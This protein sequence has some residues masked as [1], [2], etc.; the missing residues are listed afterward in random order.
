MTAHFCCISLSDM[1]SSIFIYGGG[2][3]GDAHA[4]AVPFLLFFCCRRAWAPLRFA[5]I[6]TRL[7]GGRTLGV[8]AVVVSFAGGNFR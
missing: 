4:H 3:G 1:R 7:A 5:V 6:R 8:F 2:P